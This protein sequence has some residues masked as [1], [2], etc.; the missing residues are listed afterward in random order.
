[1]NAAARVIMNLSTWDH[2]REIGVEAATMAT[3]RVQNYKHYLHCT[4][5]SHPHS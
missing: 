3:S 5:A 1:M 4:Y 2:V